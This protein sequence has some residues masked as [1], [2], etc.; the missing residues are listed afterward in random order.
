MMGVEVMSNP[1]R[2]ALLSLLM[3]A[4]GACAHHTPPAD[5]HA[6]MQARGLCDHLRGEI[7]DP[8]PED[9]QALDS[10]IDQANTA[11]A[12]TDA[13]LRALKDRYRAD[14][15]VMQLLSRY[16]DRIEANPLD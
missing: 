7:P 2:I 5:I 16:E 12:G 9:P 8:D 11:C 13:R 3:G 15:E 10:S 1:V 4:M 6:F 14:A